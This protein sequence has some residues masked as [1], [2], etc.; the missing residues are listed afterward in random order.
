[1]E[2]QNAVKRGRDRED[3]G[4]YQSEQSGGLHLGRVG[5]EP[6]TEKHLNSSI[7]R[8]KKA[9]TLRGKKESRDEFKGGQAN[10]P[11]GADIG[12]ETEHREK[13]PTWQ[14]GMEEKQ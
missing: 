7:R 4:G 6:E 11:E 14:E 2:G 8:E 13:Q 5:I 3:R 10:E 1:V 9:K 12:G